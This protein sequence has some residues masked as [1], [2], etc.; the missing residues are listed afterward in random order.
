[1]TDTA[2]AARRLYAQRIVVLPAREDGSKAPAVNTWKQYQ[3]QSPSPEDMVRWFGQPNPPRGLGVLTGPISG[4]LEMT[5]LEGRAIDDLPFL[6]LIAHDS[7]LGELWDRITGGW[8]ERSPSGGVHWFYRLPGEPAGNTKLASRPST[9]EELAVNP[10]EKMKV[11][12]ETRG[13]GGWV[14]VAPSN[15]TTHETGRPWIL[16]AG[17]PETI[18]SITM[19]ERELFHGIIGTLHQ[20]PPDE[21]TVAQERQPARPATGGSTVFGAVTPGDDYENKVDWADILQPEGWSLFFTRGNTRYW[22]RPGKSRGISATTGNDPDRDRLFVFTSATDFEQETPYTK[23]GAYAH[24]HHNGDHS[25]AASELRRSGYGEDGQIAT[26]GTPQWNA[27]PAQPAGPTSTGTT[28]FAPPAPQSGPS[29]LAP[30]PTTPSTP[31]ANTAGP[32]TGSGAFG[33]PATS[34]EGNLA[35]VT[36]LH[37][38]PLPTM[39]YTDDGNANLLIHEHGHRIRYNYDRD[40][41]LVWDGTRWKWQPKSGGL[42]REFAKQ[43]IRGIDVEGNATA[44][45]WKKKSLGASGISAMLT[46]AETDTRVVVAS[47]DLDAHPWELNTPG[48][49]VNLRTGQITPCDPTRLHTKTTKCAPDFTASRAVFEK[50]LQDTFPNDPGALRAYLQRLAGYS[51]IG[52]VRE[53]VVPFAYG[54]GGNGKGVLFETLKKLLGDYAGS[55][56]AGFLMK[57]QFQ[58]HDTELADLQGIRMLISSEVNEEDRFD[59]AKFKKLSG[60]DSIKARYMRQDFFEFEPSHTMW[61]MANHRPGVDSGGPSIWRRIQ[62][63]PFV[64]EVPEDQVVEGLERILVEEN[65]PAILAWIVE[66]AVAYTRQGINPPPEVTEATRQYSKDVD[67][68]ARFLEDECSITPNPEPGFSPSTTASATKAAYDKYCLDAGDTP[69]K[70]RNLSTQLAKHGLVIGRGVGGV[71]V[72]HGLQLLRDRARQERQL[73][74]QAERDPYG[75]DRGGH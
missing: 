14:V 39:A 46:Q 68:V 33:P 9:P 12:A 69:L 35:T 6:K 29:P 48:G 16:T 58:K 75:G 61:I 36:E 17:G 26:G 18:P 45:T 3:Q 63:I 2:A 59:E 23:F 64:H 34:T 51:A 72:Y 56:P 5:E 50:Y 47:E 55:A 62:L 38:A 53:H 57:Q 42:V 28:V 41:W 21:P 43:S 8:E 66:G 25:K 67:T 7:G 1:M 54:A 27:T 10:R 40:R 44:R 32:A 22:T 11:L 19:E 74:E 37:P 60:G 31:E 13:T 73:A 71:R 30:A 52:E 15:G 24:L 49:I 4:N 65:G 70:G 20:L